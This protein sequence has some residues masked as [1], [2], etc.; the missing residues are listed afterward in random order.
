MKSVV[1]LSQR[2]VTEQNRTLISLS[3]DPE[4]ANYLKLSCQVTNVLDG[5]KYVQPGCGKQGS[6]PP[7]KRCPAAV[8]ICVM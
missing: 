3:E 4:V 1:S 2:L 8:H 7:C 5:C 6:Y